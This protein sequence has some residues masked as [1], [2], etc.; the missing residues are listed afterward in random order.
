MSNR[1]SVPDG[2]V[3]SAP[4]ALQI[5]SSSF[6][7]RVEF[8]AVLITNY[9]AG[10]YSHWIRLTGVGTY[11]SRVRVIM[12]RAHLRSEFKANEARTAAG[13]PGCPAR[14][15]PP[16]PLRPRRDAGKRTP[17]SR[18][19][20]D[21]KVAKSWKKKP[22]AARVSSSIRGWVVVT[23]ATERSYEERFFL[24]QLEGPEL[25]ECAESRPASVGCHFGA[26]SISNSNHHQ[27]IIATT[28]KFGR[29]AVSAV[30]KP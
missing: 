8:K 30:I 7:Y 22:M 2:K 16:C 6:R 3:I 11:T 27:H 26:P 18:S 23:W 28:I 24:L 20:D 12:N 15:W 5:E 4:S 17:T 29:D 10:R 1:E 13:P 9:S 21:V 14:P 19:P 25:G